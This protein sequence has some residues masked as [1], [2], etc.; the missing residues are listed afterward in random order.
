MGPPQIIINGKDPILIST[1]F[2]YSA[3][4]QSLCKYTQRYARMNLDV[5]ILQN[6]AIAESDLF[7]ELCIG[8]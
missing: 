3:E 6:E 8:R 1:V 4:H 5:R 7:M 2:N